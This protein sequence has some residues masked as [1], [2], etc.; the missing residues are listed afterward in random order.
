MSYYCF[1]LSQPIVAWETERM[2]IPVT[3][4]EFVRSIPAEI[5]QRAQ[6]GDFDAVREVFSLAMDKGYDNEFI[7][8]EFIDFVDE[9][10]PYHN[11]REA[12]FEVTE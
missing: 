3:D 12:T 5:W 6:Q 10:S 7:D 2:Y 11:D 1:E 9:S 4:E 8:R